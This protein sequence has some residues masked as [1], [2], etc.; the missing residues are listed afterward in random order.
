MDVCASNGRA[1]LAP[2]F[3]GLVLPDLSVLWVIFFLLVLTV[4]LDRLLFRPIQRV[5]R[6]RELA[7]RSARELAERSAREAAAA[8]SE[9]EQKTSAARAEVYR[10][11]DEVRRAAM[12]ARADILAQ[13]RAQAEQEIATASAQ[14]QS[15]ADEAR[16]RLSADAEALGTAV[17]ER[18]LGR[19]AS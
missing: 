5:I 11:M 4:V 2:A 17:A 14:L 18:I 13:T 1:R 15:E 3:G 12:H 7:G 9:F 6:E 16:R 19:K 10:Q 8:A